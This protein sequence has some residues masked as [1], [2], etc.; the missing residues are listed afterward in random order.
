[1][2]KS[3]RQASSTVQSKSSNQP[4]E[5][6]AN[7]AVLDCDI[8]RDIDRDIGITSHPGDNS[9]ED[10]IILRRGFSEQYCLSN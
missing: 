9:P 3:I 4:V 1:M 5:F 2:R 10:A 8:D 6:R 7:R